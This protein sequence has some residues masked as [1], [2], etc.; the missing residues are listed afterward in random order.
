MNKNDNLLINLF[1]KAKQKI[2][3]LTLEMK[4]ENQFKKDHSLFKLYK[5][6]NMLP[7]TLS[8]YNETNITVYGNHIDKKNCII[9]DETNQKKYVIKNV[10]LTELKIMFENVEYSRIGSIFEVDETIE[11]VEVIKVKDKYYKYKKY[12]SFLL[13]KWFKKYLFGIFFIILL[14]VIKREIMVKI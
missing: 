3:E 10:K 11:E 6:G 5:K 7:I 12:N 14:K 8:G 13:Y 1:N 2:N 9:M 4:I